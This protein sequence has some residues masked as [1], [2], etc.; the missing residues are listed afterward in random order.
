MSYEKYARATSIRKHD[1]G[2]KGKGQR[3]LD[4]W[5]V[6]PSARDVYS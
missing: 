3:V 5:L 2:L 4:S 1:F 6:G